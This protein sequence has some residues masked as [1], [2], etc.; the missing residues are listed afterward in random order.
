ML[1]SK[2]YC[3]HCR[4]RSTAEA[5]V[6]G[7]G[8]D[9]SCN[10]EGRGG[11]VIETKGE[12][13]AI[14]ISFHA[15]RFSVARCFAQSLPQFASTAQ[16]H[17]DLRRNGRR[18]ALHD[19]TFSKALSHKTFRNKGS[20]PMLSNNSTR[21]A[22]VDAVDAVGDNGVGD[23]GVGDRAGGN[24]D[25]ADD[26]ANDGSADDGTDMD[27][28]NVETAASDGVV[29][30]GGPTEGAVSDSVDNRHMVVAL[31]NM[32]RKVNELTRENRKLQRSRQYYK[33]RYESAKHDFHFLQTE[34]QEQVASLS[35]SNQ[36]LRDENEGLKERL[37]KRPRTTQMSLHGR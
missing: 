33:K 14:M 21:V 8:D 27:N 20:T 16:C 17:I 26:A 37:S 29:D 5:G 35:E 31:A 28:A 19:S 7:C 18:R 3:E 6:K 23:G 13:C 2:E 25:I 10:T 12:R 22:T 11:S 9:S 4:G 1:V 34:K 30:G 24:N 32:E 15:L 36:K